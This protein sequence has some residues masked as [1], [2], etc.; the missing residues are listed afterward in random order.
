MGGIVS[1]MVVKVVKLPNEHEPVSTYLHSEPGI[2]ILP[3]W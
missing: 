3:D 1:M 2:A